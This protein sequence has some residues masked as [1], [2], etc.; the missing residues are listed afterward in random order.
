MAT[1]HE[2]VIKGFI[3][4]IPNENRTVPID[5]EKPYVGEDRCVL[6]HIQH[7]SKRD[8]LKTR[9]TK[10]PVSFLTALLL[11]ANYK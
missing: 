8:Q 1:I 7:S 6:P 11:A 2:N 5:D 3:G 9:V 10:S 4:E